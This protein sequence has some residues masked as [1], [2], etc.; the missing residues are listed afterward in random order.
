MAGRQRGQLG[1]GH[2]IKPPKLRKFM[3]EEENAEDF[4]R[5]ANTLLNL[6]Q[7][8]AKQAALW[9]ID[10]LEGAARQLVLTKNPTELDTPQKIL[11]ILKLEWGEQTSYTIRRKAYYGRNQGSV[12]SVSEFATA[13]QALWRRC[14]EGVP[15]AEQLTEDSLLFTFVDGLRTAALRRELKKVLQTAQQPISFQ[16]LV[17]IAREW[18]REEK[19]EDSARVAGQHIDELYWELSEHPSETFMNFVS[20]KDVKGGR[21]FHS[22]Y[23]PELEEMKKK[24][25]ECT[26]KLKSLTLGREEDQKEI[27]RLK[28]VA[29]ERD[30][31]FASKKAGVEDFGGG[32]RGG[33]AS[34]FRFGQQQMRPR[35]WGCGKEGHFRAQCWRGE[36]SDSNRDRF[37]DRSHFD[38]DRQRFGQKEN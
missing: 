26:E 20:G 13:I 18:M 6:H 25:N 9:I 11:G 4:I 19:V 32:D 14:N 27:A 10:S 28:K 2:P 8:P 23:N 3:G 36:V 29:M 15:I 31:E 33:V 17:Q 7:L 24:L 12:E 5:E 38:K 16:E 1:G 35:C 34:N 21:Q 37:R 30:R 22:K